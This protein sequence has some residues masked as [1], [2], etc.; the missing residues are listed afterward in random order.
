M[1]VLHPSAQNY[2]KKG[3]VLA[4]DKKRGGGLNRYPHVRKSAPFL[5]QTFEHPLL[6]SYLFHT[7]EEQ[8]GRRSYGLRGDHLPPF[9]C[10]PLPVAV[11]LGK[12]LRPNP[13]SAPQPAA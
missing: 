12:V 10:L 11:T 8:E 3:V 4:R 9:G 13:Q 7:L 2:H 1:A 6:P 5:Q